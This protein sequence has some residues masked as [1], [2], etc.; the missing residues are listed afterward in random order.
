MGKTYK[1]SKYRPE[2]ANKEKQV[3]K[4]GEKKVAKK[5]A[6]GATKTELRKYI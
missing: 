3:G 1:D 6:R 5:K 2:N 4:K